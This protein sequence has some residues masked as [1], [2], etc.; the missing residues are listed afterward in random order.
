[1]PRRFN[2]CKLRILSCRRH[3]CRMA[4]SIKGAEN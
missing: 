1:L 3:F 4:P 2:S